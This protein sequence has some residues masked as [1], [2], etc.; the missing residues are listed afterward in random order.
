MIKANTVAKANCKIRVMITIFQAC[1]SFPEGVGYSTH[2]EQV[3][4]SA[5]IGGDY[6]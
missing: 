3:Y 4:G 6:G 2:F 1:L 5:G